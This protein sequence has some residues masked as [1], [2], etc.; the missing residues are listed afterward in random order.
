M[1]EAKKPVLVVDDHEDTR[2]MVATMLTD[3]GFDV[4]QAANGKEAIDLLVSAGQVEPCLIVLDLEMPV[5]TGWEFLAIMKSYHR[6]SSIPVVVTSG[7][8]QKSEALRHGAVIAY[9]PKP[10]NLAGLLERVRQVAH[11]HCDAGDGE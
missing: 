8:Q 11:Q 1:S 3:S 6:L 10:V 5:M 9:L 2:E 4:V 7:S